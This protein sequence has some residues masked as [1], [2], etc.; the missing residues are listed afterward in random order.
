MGHHVIRET[1]QVCVLGTRGSCWHRGERYEMR[2]EGDLGQVWGV[3]DGH[4]RTLDLILE[5]S[6]PLVAFKI[7]PLVL[8]LAA[9]LA[10]ESRGIKD[11]V[12]GR[13]AWS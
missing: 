7:K 3:S 1:E 2:L 4:L 8:N 10:T 9:G 13:M 5:V 6:G 12:R 11:Q